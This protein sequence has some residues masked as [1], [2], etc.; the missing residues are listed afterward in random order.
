MNKQIKPIL[1]E[2]GSVLLVSL[3]ILVALTIISGIALKTTNHELKL[4]RNDKVIQKLTSKTESTSYAAIE[5]LESIPGKDLIKNNS[6]GGVNLP[7]MNRISTSRFRGPQD[8]DEFQTT[9]KTVKDKSYWTSGN[10]GTFSG[11]GN[12][13]FD[14]EFA[15][16]QYSVFDVGVAPGA[17]LKTGNSYSKSGNMNTNLHNFASAGLCTD[18]ASKRMILVG[19]R[20]EY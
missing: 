10:P 12:T 18:R 15:N 1:D 17:S 19:Y 14:G 16:C 2:K 8:D 3:V 9:I 6:V 11:T 4:S 20:R 13:V 5:T 7:W